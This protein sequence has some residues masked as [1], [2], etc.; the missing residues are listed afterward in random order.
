MTVIVIILI[1]VMV[2]VKTVV[3]DSVASILGVSCRHAAEDAF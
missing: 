2:V 1:S 3:G